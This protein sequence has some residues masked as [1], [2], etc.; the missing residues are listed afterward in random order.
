[1]YSMDA[2]TS[3]RQI[4]LTKHARDRINQFGLQFKQAIQ[5]LKNSTQDGYPDYIKHKGYEKQKHG[6]NADHWRNGEYIFTTIETRDKYTN[7]DIIL[8]ITMRREGM[9][10]KPITIF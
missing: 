5:L 6:D 7:E 9:G 10:K 2:F 4:K 8:V 3:T 1:M